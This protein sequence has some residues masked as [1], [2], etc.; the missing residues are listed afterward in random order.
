MK[1][2]YRYQG[3]LEIHLKRFAWKSTKI[4]IL[5]GVGQ[6]REIYRTLSHILSILDDFFT[7]WRR[8]INPKS[9]KISTSPL[10]FS[11]ALPPACSLL[12]TISKR[13]AVNILKRWQRS[14]RTMNIN[15]YVTKIEQPVWHADKTWVQWVILLVKLN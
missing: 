10:Q 3:I 9:T 7:E 5:S 4:E 14:K 15:E 6:G 1:L 2:F 13:R 8:Q 11:L 12:N